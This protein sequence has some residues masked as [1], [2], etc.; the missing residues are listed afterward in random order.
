M[1]AR[2]LEP[3]VMDGADEAEEYD[4][5]RHSAVNTVFVSDLLTEFESR[6]PRPNGAGTGQS[7]R[8]LDVGTGTALIAIELCL[9]D[10]SVHVVAIDLSEAMLQFAQANVQR[11]GLTDQ[12]ALR[13]ADAREVLAAGAFQVVMS[14]SLIHHLAQPGPALEAMWSAVAPGGLLF[15]RDL[16]RP[17][18]PEQLEATVSRVAGEDTPTQQQLLRQ[19]LHAA[20]TEQELIGLLEELGWNGYHLQLTSDRHWTLFRW[21]ALL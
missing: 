15:L 7:V 10:P 21:R 19:S 17:D 18:T 3:E 11:S 5:M 12:L 20:L 9:R 16:F 13:L 4:L 1:L 8:V 6:F 14:N 2:V